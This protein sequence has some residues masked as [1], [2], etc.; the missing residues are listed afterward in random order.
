MKKIY[1]L[2][3]ITISSLFYF[4]CASNEGPYAPAKRDSSP[5][6][7]NKTVILDKELS[8]FIAVDSQ[9]AERTDGGKLKTMSNVRNRTNQDLTVQVQTVFRDL[10]GF[11]VGDDTAWETVVLTANETRTIAAISTNKKAESYTVR[12]RMMR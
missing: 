6:I 5:E 4:G 3:F 8:D 1:C 2:F 12:I 10:N 11:S 9:N 7:E